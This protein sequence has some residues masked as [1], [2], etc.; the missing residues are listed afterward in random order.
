MD[1]FPD[2]V[3]L[4]LARVNCTYCHIT[5]AFGRWE[6]STP[7]RVTAWYGIR[8]ARDFNGAYL[9]PLKTV[10]PAHRLGPEGDGP[11][12][13]CET[14]HKGAYKPLYGVSML[15]VY[16]ELAG[17]MSMPTPPP[18]AETGPDAPAE[19]EV[20]PPVEPDTTSS[21]PAH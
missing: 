7:Q 5:R 14:C 16:P 8:M 12:I 21:G 20:Q 18:V 2:D 15:R 4:E 19:P 6:Q 13:G 17:V 10:F 11:K 3:Y 1:R 9:N